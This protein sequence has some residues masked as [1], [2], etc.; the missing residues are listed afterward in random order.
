MK[1]V[2]IT[3]PDIPFKGDLAYAL[4]NRDDQ[5]KY[6]RPIQIPKRMKYYESKLQGASLKAFMLQ[7]ISIMTP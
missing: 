1:T 3:M 5:E 4:A 6:Y 7:I 2:R